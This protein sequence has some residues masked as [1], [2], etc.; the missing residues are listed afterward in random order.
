M[1]KEKPQAFALVSSL[2]VAS[3]LNIDGESFLPCGVPA[4]KRRERHRIRISRFTSLLALTPGEGQAA[5]GPGPRAVS[6][7]TP[8]P[9]GVGAGF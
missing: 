6:R 7:V 2:E 3:G 9:C 5:P 4:D 1:S 8:E